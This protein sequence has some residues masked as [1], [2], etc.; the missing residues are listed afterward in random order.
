MHKVLHSEY[1]SL[2]YILNIV[3]G[4]ILAICG[5]ILAWYL[6]K[7]S[8]AHWPVNYVLYAIIIGMILRNLVKLPDMFKGGLGF[9]S[10]I[11]LYSGVILLGG[12]INI[13]T[14]LTTGMNA[15]ILAVL[16]VSLSITLSYILGGIFKLSEDSKALLGVGMGVCGVS[17]ITAVAPVINAK[18]KNTLTAIVASLLNSMIFIFIIPI[19]VNWIGMSEMQSGY[20]VGAIS[21]NTAQA[22][23][24]GFAIG[25][26]AGVTATITKTARNALMAFVILFFAYA[27]AKK[28]LSI[29]V[30]LKPSLVWDKFPKFIL[31][32]LVM[33]LLTTIGVFSKGTIDEFSVISKW[34]FAICFVGI[35]YD[36]NLMEITIKD[37]K[38]ILFGLLLTLI[39][40]I[41][42]LIYIIMFV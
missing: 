41:V 39:L 40:A 29:G 14:V 38:P 16:A 25:D 10:K 24:T 22:I 34:S 12:T 20:W 7:I 17:A 4:L 15:I 42:T 3:P 9:S 18:T 28:G 19:L 37:L 8:P 23:A 5:A 32:L 6:G 2:K 36:I 1:G 26:N 31:G 21:S 11:L 30:K 35:G 13:S 33:S 27:Y